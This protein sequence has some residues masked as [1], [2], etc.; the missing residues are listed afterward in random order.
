MINAPKGT[1]DLLP[2]RA[3]AWQSM[4]DTAYRVFGDYGYQLIETPIFE[5]TGMFVRGIGESTDV[6]GKEMFSVRSMDGLKAERESRALKAGQALSLRPEGTASVV[7][8][9]REHNLVPQGGAP[10]K[11]MYAGPMFRCER[12]QKGRLREFHQIGVEC[13][14]AS[15]PSADAEVIIMLMRFFETL[16]IPRVSM[17]LLV[18]SMGDDACRPAYRTSVKEYIQDHSDQLCDECNR[19]AETNPCVP[20]TARTMPAARSWMARPSSPTRSATTV[21]PTTSR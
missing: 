12:P 19:R 3:R 10:A 8:A 14:G 15:E 13:L 6:V 11:L 7:R 2:E 18:N 16:G 9:V 21:A 4:C 5:D 17:R 20:S 1:E